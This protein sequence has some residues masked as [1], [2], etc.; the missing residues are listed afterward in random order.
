MAASDNRIQI[1]DSVT[2]FRINLLALVCFL[3][4]LYGINVFNGSTIEPNHARLI[5]YKMCFLLLCWS[6]PVVVLE[7]FDCKRLRDFDRS[8][9][10]LRRV[11]IMATGL[12]LTVSLC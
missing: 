8:Q 12:Y 11:L 2:S 9:V 5:I 1:P 3:A 10:S 7:L 4:G 6:V